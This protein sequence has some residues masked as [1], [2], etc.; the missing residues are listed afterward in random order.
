MS[1]VEALRASRSKEG[2]RNSCV[3]G[4]AYE[5]VPKDRLSL[6]KLVRPA[7]LERE[8][9]GGDAQGSGVVGGENKSEDEGKEREESETV[10]VSAKEGHVPDYFLRRKDISL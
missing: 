1:W 7:S 6:T 10:V 3:G 4:W 2:N 8:P 5:L 9:V